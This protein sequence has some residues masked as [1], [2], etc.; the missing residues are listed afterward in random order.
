MSRSVLSVI[1]LHI[2]PSHTELEGHSFHLILLT[3]KTWPHKVWDY[4]GLLTWR[5][6][7]R[8]FPST[9]SSCWRYKQTEDSSQ[10]VFKRGLNFNLYLNYFLIKY[11]RYQ[12]PLFSWFRNHKSQ[13]ENAKLPELGMT[14][15]THGV[16]Y[17]AHSDVNSLQSSENNLKQTSTVGLQGSC[18]LLSRSI[19]HLLRKHSPWVLSEILHVGGCLLINTKLI[20]HRK[21]KGYRRC[22]RYIYIDSIASQ[23]RPSSHY[24]GMLF[25]TTLSPCLICQI[26]SFGSKFE[27]VVHVFSPQ[28]YQA[29]YKRSFEI[30]LITWCFLG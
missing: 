17:K 12:K 9:L 30:N 13:E 22:L 27:F 5:K 10:S 4:K 6:P 3:Q 2:R 26:T 14:T 24:S 7:A 23:E 28:W 29:T 16:Y 18:V 15:D 11:S 20:D 1:W 8:L 21:R 19:R 25:S